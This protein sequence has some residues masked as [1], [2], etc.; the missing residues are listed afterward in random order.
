MILF[1]VS[2]SA[3]QERQTTLSLQPG[4]F[5][6]CVYDDSW[7]IET[8]V[9]RSDENSDALVSFMQQSHGKFFLPS[10]S[11]KCW[12]PFSCVVCNV[13]SVPES[14]GAGLLVLSKEDYSKASTLFKT[15]KSN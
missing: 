7:Y 11:D 12:I 8:V 10:R 15:F 3:E 9:E 13:T 6:A 4:N 14:H 5:I 1:N 2:G